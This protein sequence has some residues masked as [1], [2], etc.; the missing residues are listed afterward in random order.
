MLSKYIKEANLIFHVDGGH[1]W[2]KVSKEF[3]HKT[4]RTMKNIRCYSYYDNENYYLEEDVDANLYLKNL[5]AEKVKVNI[6]FKDDGDY[7]PIRELN[8]IDSQL[9]SL[10]VGLYKI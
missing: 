7:S 4:N 8:R 6:T 9:S 3:F 2:L 5:K 10:A 1:G